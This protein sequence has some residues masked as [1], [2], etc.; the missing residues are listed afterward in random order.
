MVTSNLD[1]ARWVFGERRPRKALDDYRTRP[2]KRA[3]VWC[4]YPSARP[5]SNPRRQWHWEPVDFSRLEGVGLIVEKMAEDGW[6][7]TVRM[8]AGRFMVTVRRRVTG[9]HR[10]EVRA[11]ELHEA[12]G[13]A[14]VAACRERM[15]R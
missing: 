12:V 14:C 3:W 8:S 5:R 1:I 11:D 4:R 2:R 9:M 15:E 7:V 6:S 13:R 10:T